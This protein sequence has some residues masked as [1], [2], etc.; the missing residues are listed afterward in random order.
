MKNLTCQIY[1]VVLS[2]EQYWNKLE[3]LKL[4]L[5]RQK[6]ARVYVFILFIFFVVA[7]VTLEA[8]KIVEFSEDLHLCNLDKQ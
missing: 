5:Y 7:S 1:K 3:L 8:L 2:V 4:H 6:R